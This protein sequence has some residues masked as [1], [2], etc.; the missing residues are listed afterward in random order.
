MNEETNKK[1]MM[2]VIGIILILLIIL[3][4]DKM[5]THFMIL[6]TIRETAKNLTM[7]SI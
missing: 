5:Y 1:V 2:V 3:T 7:N 4:I 6:E